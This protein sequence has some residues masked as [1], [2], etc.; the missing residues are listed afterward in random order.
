M[1]LKEARWP[2]IGLVGEGL[3]TTGGLGLG[4]I[5]MFNMHSKVEVSDTTFTENK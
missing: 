5:K 3:K 4:V 2:I 1:A